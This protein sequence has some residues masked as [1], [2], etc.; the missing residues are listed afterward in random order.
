MIAYFSDK[1][2]DPMNAAEHPSF[3]RILSAGKWMYTKYTHAGKNGVLAHLASE[4]QLDRMPSKVC[5][6]GLVY[7]GYVKEPTQDELARENVPNSFPVTLSG[8]RVID[9]PLAVAAP[10]ALSFDGSTQDEHA[11][12]FGREAFRIWE[13]IEQKKPPTDNECRHLIYLAIN[14]NYKVTA[15]LLTQLRWVTDVDVVPILLA[16]SGRDPKHAAVAG[17]TSGQSAAAG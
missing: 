17:N 4:P 6:D 3:T 11:S 7:F 8:G 13:G 5:S 14:Q 16:I 15:E 1:T 2:G 9:I 10:M 12:E